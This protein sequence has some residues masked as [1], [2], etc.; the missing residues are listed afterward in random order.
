[1]PTFPKDVILHTVFFYPRYG[2]SYRDLEENMIERGVTLDHA[3][4]NRWVERY[5]GQVAEH[6]RR[7]KRSTDRSWRMDETY[8]KVNGL[9]QK[10]SS[11]RVQQ[12]PKVSRTSTGC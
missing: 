2:V 8:I 10:I 11:T 3:T 7:R 9:P 6:A 12:T 5:A 1:V 4:P